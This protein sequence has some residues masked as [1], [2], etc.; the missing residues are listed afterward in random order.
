MV[1]HKC[2]TPRVD[3]PRPWTNI[4]IHGM[5][6][7]SPVDGLTATR[8]FNYERR[9]PGLRRDAISWPPTVSLPQNE[10]NTKYVQDITFGEVSNSQSAKS[11]FPDNSQ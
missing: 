8:E 9:A 3:Q 5:M 7:P 11:K 10:P 4:F 6:C 1:S 2:C